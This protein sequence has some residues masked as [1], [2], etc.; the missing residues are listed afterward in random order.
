VDVSTV[1]MPKQKEKITPSAKALAFNPDLAKGTTLTY[2]TTIEAQGQK[3]T[4]DTVC[5]TSREEQE[6]KAVIR[7]VITS[8]GAM[9]DSTNTIDFDAETLMPRRQHTTQGTGEAELGF[10]AEGVSGKISMGAQEMPVDFKSDH[11]VLPSEWGTLIP[12]STL[13]LEAGYT[14]TIHQFDLMTMSAKA[15]I[16]KVAGMEK[17]TVKAGTFDTYKVDLTPVEGEGD[18]AFWIETTTRNILKSEA[19]LPPMMGGGS[20]ITELVK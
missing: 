6:G 4:M 2:A 11:Q 12:L 16:M 19:K 7:V 17:L 18:S 9:G 13:P 1:E 20:V 5:T 8:T 14:E 3:M 15:M 10:S